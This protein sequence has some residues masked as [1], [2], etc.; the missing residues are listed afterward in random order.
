MYFVFLKNGTF[1]CPV[2][3]S[4]HCMY[5]AHILKHLTQSAGL[6]SLNSGTGTVLY[7]M[8]QLGSI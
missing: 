2:L 4:W 6:A 7:G 8:G 3:G 1:C 5:S